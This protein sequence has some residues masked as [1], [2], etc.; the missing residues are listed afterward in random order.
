[1][2]DTTRKVRRRPAPA[3]PT[4]SSK[5]E[6]EDA[7]FEPEQEKPRRSRREEAADEDTPRRSR[8]AATSDDDADES[9]RPVLSGGWD[10]FEKTKAEVP[11]QF[12]EEFK[13]PEG[14]TVV[15]FLD[16]GP[17]VTYKQHWVEGLPQ[18]SKKS[19][20]C[21]GDDCPLCDI[22]ND[23]AVI[24]GFNIFHLQQRKNLYILLRITA[25]SA[26]A[27]LSAKKASSPINRDDLYWVITKEVKGQ[28]RQKKT[29]TSFH[30]VK[31]RDLEE[32][33]E[34]SP[35]TDDQIEKAEANVLTA[36]A[37]YT[38]SRSELA[39]VAEQAGGGDD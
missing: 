11:S 12:G 30:P 20:V 28:G 34:I 16:E 36:K 25:A 35:L 10:G 38:H 13:I 39:E 33:W 31:E 1:M 37:I 18:G 6:N 26:I 9:D 2:T 8:R 14:D 4:T 3:A 5:Y 29:I 24:S 7:D 15:K 27:N 17:F 23:V 22:G 19:W 32:D 21:V